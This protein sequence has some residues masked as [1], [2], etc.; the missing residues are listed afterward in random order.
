M[1][2]SSCCSGR[3]PRAPQNEKTEGW[4]RARAH[5]CACARRG[6]PSPRCA[7]SEVCHG[8][9]VRAPGHQAH[10]G[11]KTHRPTH[12]GIGHQTHGTTKTHRPHLRKRSPNARGDQVTSAAPPQAVS[13]HTGR[14]RH[15]GHTS[16]SGH[17]THGTTKTHRPGEPGA[18]APTHFVMPHWRTL[19]CACGTHDLCRPRKGARRLYR[20]HDGRSGSPPPTRGAGLGDGQPLRCPRWR[21]W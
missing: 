7:K 19:G 8:R 18:W 13:N 16:S 6:V 21:T 20:A 4:P 14:P 2:T 10:G 1:A 17:Q 15:I 12:L 11:T 9:V 5:V 3:A